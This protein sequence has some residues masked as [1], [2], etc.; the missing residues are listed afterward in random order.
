MFKLALEPLVNR[1]ANFQRPHS[2]G[3]YNKLYADRKRP[4]VDLKLRFGATGHAIEMLLTTIAINLFVLCLFR[5]V[6]G[7]REWPILGRFLTVRYRAISF[8]S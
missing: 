3:R 7:I 4:I 2:T 6:V 1:N 8:D 5:E